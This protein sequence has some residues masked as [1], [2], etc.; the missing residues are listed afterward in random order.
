MKLLEKLLMLMKKTIEINFFCKS[1]HWSRRMIRIKDIVN[2]IIIVTNLGFK[3]RNFYFLNLIFIDDKKIKR[4]NNIYRNK[5]KATDVLTFVKS[6]KNI[7]NKNEVY[8]DI[9]FSDKTIK[10][11]AKKNLIDFYDHVTH[12]IIHCFLHVNGYDHKKNSDFIQMKD[13]E[14]KILMKLNIKSPYIL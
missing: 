12:L 2:N 1:N 9:F 13:L 6:L 10:K 8:C 3:K 14:E 5:N 7:N 4:I 11:D